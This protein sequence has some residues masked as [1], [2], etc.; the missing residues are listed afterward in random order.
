MVQAWIEARYRSLQ[1]RRLQLDVNDYELSLA[2]AAAED[3]LHQAATGHPDFM[4]AVKSM[5]LP[6]V[7]PKGTKKKV[8]TPSKVKRQRL[9]P[10]VLFK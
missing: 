10:G 6:L 7:K 8:P 4:D 2:E 9:V 5:D 3:A 1:A